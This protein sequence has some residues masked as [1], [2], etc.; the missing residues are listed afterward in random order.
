MMI[1]ALIFSAAYHCPSAHLSK[2]EKLLANLLNFFNG[3][4]IQ[5]TSLPVE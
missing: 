2:R 5:A 3:L 4:Y 1:R